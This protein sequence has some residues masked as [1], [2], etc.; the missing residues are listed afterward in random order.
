MD[1]GFGAVFLDVQLMIKEILILQK[2]GLEI[3][4]VVKPYNEEDS[5]AV[6]M[7]LIQDQV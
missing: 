1:Y 4:T 6:K 5:F 3:K 7:R 2:Y